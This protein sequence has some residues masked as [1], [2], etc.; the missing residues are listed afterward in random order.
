MAKYDFEKIVKQATVSKDAEGAFEVDLRPLHNHVHRSFAKTEAQAR[1]ETI[2]V[3]G[4]MQS[5]S[6]NSG[7]EFTL[8]EGA[9]LPEK[10]PEPV[11]HSVDDDPEGNRP[12]PEQYAEQSGIDIDDVEILDP[13]ELAAADA[14][15]EA[16]ARGEQPNEAPSE[17]PAT[18]EE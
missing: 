15:R 12:S 10:Q 1:K 6:E 18:D 8:P 17:E 2:E 16:E 3:L 9:P 5:Q 11:I 14:A 13:E 7:I 4:D